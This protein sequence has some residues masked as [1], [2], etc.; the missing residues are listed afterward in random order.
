LGGV[1][2]A[3]GV[4]V[5]LPVDGAGALDGEVDGAAVCAQAPCAESTP[6]T[7]EIRKIG[8]I[9]NGPWML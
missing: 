8:F 3:A 7:T 6:K 2:G 9:D 1:A 5:A 4:L